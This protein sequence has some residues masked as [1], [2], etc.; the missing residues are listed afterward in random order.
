MQ[1]DI[2]KKQYV[3]AITD[4]KS[5]SCAHTFK[6]GLPIVAQWVKNLTQYREAVGLIPG[7]AQW[8][9]D[10]VLPQAAVQVADEAQ[11]WCCCGCCIDIRPLARELPYSAS[12]ALKRK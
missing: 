4:R 11:I 9:K 6:N 8:I 7:L 3:G 2:F 1:W 5:E 10:P 12:V